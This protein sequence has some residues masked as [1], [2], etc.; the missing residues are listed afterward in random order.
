MLGGT[1]VPGGR[2]PS[3]GQ[4]GAPPRWG[5][6]PV[7]GKGTPVLVREGYPKKWYPPSQI[8]MEYP[9]V[10]SVWG[11]PWPRQDEA[12][13]CP[14]QVTL[15]QVILRTVCLL[16]FPAEDC[17]VFACRIVRKYGSWVKVKFTLPLQIKATSH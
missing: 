11:T 1:Q 16:R 15:V 3:P 2:Y 13:P 7:P 10:R 12:T 17:L 9:P 5:D 8:R 6:T 14:G 4:E